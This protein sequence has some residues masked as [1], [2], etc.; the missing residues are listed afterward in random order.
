[1]GSKHD[2][3]LIKCVFCS[4]FF[5]RRTDYIVRDNAKKNYISGFILQGRNIIFKNILDVLC[6][7]SKIK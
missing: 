7:L 1:M 2:S 4:V 3:F 5:S 6:S